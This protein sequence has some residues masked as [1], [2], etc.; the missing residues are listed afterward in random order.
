MSENIP[1]QEK[2]RDISDP[3]HCR[4]SAD[5]STTLMGARG[6]KKL[7]MQNPE[8]LCVTREGMELGTPS[9]K[10]NKGRKC[11]LEETLVPGIPAAKLLGAGGSETSPQPVNLRT[12]EEKL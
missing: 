12:C 10:R 8:D 4:F 2:R 9:W 5:V 3:V 1:E 11:W 7:Q 6:R